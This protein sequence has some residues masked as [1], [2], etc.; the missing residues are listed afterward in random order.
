MDDAMQS[1]HY[2]ILCKAVVI[3]VLCAFLYSLLVYYMQAT[4]SLDKTLFDVENV[5]ASDYTVEYDITP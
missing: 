5:T 1:E 3:V 2:L 4:A